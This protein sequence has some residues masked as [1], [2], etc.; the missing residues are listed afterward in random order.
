MAS[1]LDQQQARPFA[2]AAACRE[3][4]SLRPIGGQYRRHLPRHQSG[5]D[6]APAACGDA[7]NVGGQRNQRPGQDVG[8]HQIIGRAGADR[9]MAGSRSG[10]QREA[11]GAVAD[12]YAVD[13]SIGGLEITS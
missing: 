9:D 12:S 3:A 2:A 11:T 1:P 4:K 10:A 5:Q 6:D 8:D 13:R 7:R